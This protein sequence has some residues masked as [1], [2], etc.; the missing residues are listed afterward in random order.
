MVNTVNA[1][2]YSI[3]FELVISKPEFE[4]LRAYKSRLSLEC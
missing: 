1:E 2:I 4:F 3:I